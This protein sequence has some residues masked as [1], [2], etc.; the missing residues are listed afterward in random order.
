M[1]SPQAVRILQCDAIDP[2]RLGIQTKFDVKLPKFHMRQVLVLVVCIA[3]LCAFAIRGRSDVNDNHCHPMIEQ[4]ISYG[5]D[6]TG[7]R[8]LVNPASIGSSKKIRMLSVANGEFEWID[9]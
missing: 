8:I 5:V 9:L 7:G 6:S 3:T 1:S 2:F 4:W